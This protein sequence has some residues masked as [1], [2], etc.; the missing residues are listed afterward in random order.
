MSHD[1]EI[2]DYL[3]KLGFPILYI[4]KNHTD[5]ICKEAIQ[6][7]FYGSHQIKYIKNKKYDLCL[8]A[9]RQDGIA[10]Q[11]IKENQQT[12]ELC[13]EAV[14]QNGL[15]LQ[16]VGNELKSFR[17]CLAAVKQNGLAIQYVKDEIYDIELF[18]TEYGIHLNEECIICLEKNNLMW[19]KLKCNHL[20]HINCLNK[21]IK[22]NKSC[23]NCRVSL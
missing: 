1:R 6:Q 15:A 4:I 20:F 18:R 8:E 7:K 22:E 14:K 9:V 10:L 23:P 12:E 17:I 16:Y 3:K 11:Y 2:I 21:W 13:L 5:E 19:C